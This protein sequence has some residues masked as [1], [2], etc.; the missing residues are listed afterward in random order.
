MSTG[1]GIR[2]LSKK[3]NQLTFQTYL[4]CSDWE[5]L[6]RTYDFALLVIGLE[7][8]PD[9]PLGKSL[10]G[11]DF[12]N[13]LYEVAQQYILKM[14]VNDFKNFPFTAEFLTNTAEQ[15]LK[16]LTL[17][18][19]T[20][21][22]PIEDQLPQ[23]TYTLEV[24]MPQWLDHIKVG[25]VWEVS[26]YVFDNAAWYLEHP[27][28]ETPK[29]YRVYKEH[30]QWR[31]H[32]GSI[33]KKGRNVVARYVR[34][35]SAAERQVKEKLRPAKG[36]RLVYKNFDTPFGIEQELIAAAQK[37]EAPVD[38]VPQV[39]SDLLQA[40]KEENVEK[41]KAIL[42]TGFDPNECRDEWERYLLE[43]IAKDTYRMTPEKMEIAK[44]LLEHGADPNLGRYG[45]FL[46]S[47]CY[48][49]RGE[50][51]TRLLVEYGADITLIDSVDKNS[52]LQSAAHSNMVWLVK[53][54]L[55]AGVDVNYKSRNRYTA[56]YYA[57]STSYSITPNVEQNAIEI[58][59]L[60]LANGAELNYFNGKSGT[61]LHA[62]CGRDS[63]LE[64]A[65][66][67]IELGA[68][69]HASTTEGFQPIHSAAASGEVEVLK[70][71]ISKGANIHQADG[72]GN[73]PIH[74][75]AG[76]VLSKAKDRE[77]KS[78]TKM[79][80]WIKTGYPLHPP[81]VKIGVTTTGAIVDNFKRE[82]KVTA[83]QA[84]IL[85]ELL[86]LGLDP[87][88]TNEKKTNLF[89]IAA[90][91][92]HPELLKACLNHPVPLLNQQDAFG[93]TPLHYAALH[94]DKVCYDI[95]IQAGADTSLKSRK[96]R[97]IAKKRF[98][99]GTKASDVR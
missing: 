63:C 46:A 96:I 44:C 95:L 1:Y 87:G 94:D 73:L 55:E 5:V 57:T 28:P 50:E 52:V 23:A 17:F 2:V 84:N 12:V 37:K 66:H 26:A 92:N 56:L 62:A 81:S 60:L 32:Y 54:C 49:D 51:M 14:E 27:D 25:D 16:T 85:C 86:E 89:H 61:A 79:R 3:D 71:L 69:I 7:A 42:A 67:L 10:E 75:I 45:T 90:R 74:Y 72:K 47:V 99:S 76:G 34:S 97:K 80:Y 43:S 68:D 53:K 98:A 40:A 4:L 6:P 64:V 83:H 82:K 11:K 39:S 18:K 24:T 48:S 38:Q 30:G 13:N 15:A 20:N 88:E 70:L 31:N 59:D 8:P 93:W 78:L 41:V 29:F 77:S 21:E 9:S 35:Y 91:L 58:I 22:F 36:Y 65:Q 33:G 19:D